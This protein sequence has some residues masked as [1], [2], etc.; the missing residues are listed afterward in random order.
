QGEGE[1][2]PWSG[3]PVRELRRGRRPLHR[4]SYMPRRDGAAGDLW[5]SELPDQLGS[6]GPV[7]HLSRAHEVYARPVSP[8]RPLRLLLREEQEE[9]PGLR[10][11]PPHGPSVTGPIRAPFPD[12]GPERLPECRL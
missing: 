2:V 4:M 7:S 3:L 5:L 1:E 10:E 6:T 8:L 9:L 11:A 12:E